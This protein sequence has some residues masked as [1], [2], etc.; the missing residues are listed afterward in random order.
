M[1]AALRGMAFIET[2][3]AS[4]HSEQKWLPLAASH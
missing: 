3:S 2:M 4:Q 1:A